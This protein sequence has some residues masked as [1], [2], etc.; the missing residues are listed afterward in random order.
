MDPP[1]AEAKCI[2]GGG[3]APVRK[4]LRRKEKNI[5]ATAV[6]RVRLCER[7]NCADTRVNETDPH[8]SKFMRN[9]SLRGGLM[10]VFVQNC[11]PWEWLH[12]GAGEESSPWGG[13]VWWSDGNPTML[14]CAASEAGGRGMEREVE[15]GKQ[16]GVGGRCCKILLPCS[17]LIVNKLNWFPQIE[18]VLPMTVFGECSPLSFPWPTSFHFIFSPLFSWQGECRTALVGTWHPARVNLPQKWRKVPSLELHSS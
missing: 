13:D 14:P 2:H 6:R 9:C 7:N 8:C 11:F 15:P 17:D 4:Y 3:R 5:W 12:A 16:G 10:L 18:S 1:L